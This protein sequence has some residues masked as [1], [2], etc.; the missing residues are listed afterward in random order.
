MP[1]SGGSWSSP[2]LNL[3]LHPFFLHSDHLVNFRILGF[4]TLSQLDEGWYGKGM[5]FTSSAIY[6]L[7]YMKPESPAMILC[8]TCPGSIYAVVES[9]A[10]PNS[11]SG[12]AL[13][14]GFVRCPQ[15]P[16]PPSSNCPP[17]VY[18]L[19]PSPFGDSRFRGP[20]DTNNMNPPVLLVVHF[21]FFV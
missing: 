15:P 19:L 17:C 11:I 4:A 21:S 1:F 2:A 16:L 9:P 13:K 3:F 20:T 10:G 7:L 6:S 8:W 14:G 5:Y 18:S 12:S